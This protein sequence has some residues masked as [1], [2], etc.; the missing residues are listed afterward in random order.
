M[1]I[2]NIFAVIGQSP[3]LLNPILE[4]VQKYEQIEQTKLTQPDQPL[5]DYCR[6]LLLKG[7]CLRHLQQHSRVSI[8][9]CYQFHNSLSFCSP[10]IISISPTNAFSKL[11]TGK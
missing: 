9:T 6:C 8:L 7:M 3:H 10:K 11:S 5:D 4:R 2:W 1:Y